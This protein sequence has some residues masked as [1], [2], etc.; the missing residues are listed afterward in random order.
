MGLI[1]LLEILHDK[2]TS[3]NGTNRDSGYVAGGEHEENSDILTDMHV[4]STPHVSSVCKIY[5]HNVLKDNI[6]QS[7][8]TSELNDKHSHN[9]LLYRSEFTCTQG[10]S[11]TVPELPT[12]EDTSMF[13]KTIART[14]PLIVIF[15]QTYNKNTCIH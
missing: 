12:L 6:E 9:G 13:P 14:M 4:T 2:K 11:G 8:S 7:F 1:Q 3:I 15:L 5:E 10:H